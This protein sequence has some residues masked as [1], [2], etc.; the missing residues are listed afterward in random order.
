M[1]SS[2]IAFVSSSVNAIKYLARSKPVSTAE[3][4]QNTHELTD[5]ELRTFGEPGKNQ[6]FRQVTGTHEDAMDFVI[7]QTKSLTE[8]APGKL[9]GYNSRG[10]E[11]RIYARFKVS[12]TSIRITGVQGLKGIKFMWP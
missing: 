1:V 7:S 11:F 2:A 8:Y 5:A 9:V 6:G 12:Y 3:L 10:V 4:A